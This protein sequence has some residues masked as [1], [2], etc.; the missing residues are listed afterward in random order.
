M[1]KKSLAKTFP[2]IAKQWH[3]TK[4]EDLSPNEVA[5]FSH[6][7]VWWKCPKGDDHEYQQSISAKSAGKG[8]PV[9]N[10]RK[11][12]PSTSLMTTHPKI[13]TQWHP[14][15]NGNLTPYD[16]VKGSNK[17]AWWKCPKGDD[18]EWRS[19]INSKTESC[20]ICSGSK[21]V[22]SNCLATTNPELAKE[23]HPTK[24]GKLTPYDFVKFSNKRV[25]W[26]CPKGDD[27][28]W[29]TAISN[30]SIGNGCPICSGHVYAKSTS[31]GS[32]NPSLSMDWHPTKNG[33]LTPYDVQPSSN[34][35]VWWKCPKGDDHE[36]ITSLSN[37]SRGKGCPIC[38]GLKVVPSNCLS[39]TNPKLAEEWH[40]NKNGKLT[41]LMVNMFSSKKVWWRC[42][43]N[44][45]HVWEASVKNRNN[46]TGCP[47]CTP[48]GF[49]KEHIGYFYVH[50]IY[51]KSGKNIAL[52]FGVTNKFGVRIKTI[53]T[54]LNIYDLKNIFY[55][56]GDGKIVFE[57]ENYIKKK[58]ITSF[59]N[60]E[61]M[62]NG[63][64]ETIKYSDK[65]LVEIYNLCNKKLKF[66]SGKKLYMERLLNI[67]N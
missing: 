29:I 60:K 18:H 35:R 26:K 42:K 9:C 7:K 39:M 64:T 3:P 27:H 46:G 8:C 25:W 23:W 16:V 12:V 20:P 10:G 19:I 36:W 48:G 54:G 49:S 67:F 2:K 47:I 13:A 14:T 38:E 53:K 52:K 32:V 51:H 56:E 6:K 24:N 22:L 50:L 57:I 65:T 63:H 55:F 28:E 15:K 33:K 59:L 43:K 61:I 30:R 62:S 5:P 45:S 41:P 21:V 17:Y 4:N 58:Y 34:R 40:P 66:K 31:L 1:T 37:R 11:V 44:R